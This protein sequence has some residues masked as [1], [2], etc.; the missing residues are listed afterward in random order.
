MPLIYLSASKA[1]IEKISAYE[2]GFD[3]F[4]E[5]RQPFDVRFY[6]VSILFIIFDLEI[7]FLFPLGCVALLVGCVWF[8]YYD[9]I[10]ININYWIF[11]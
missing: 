10:S 2:C 7:T 5:V 3:P 4:G 6:L 8:F 9:F 1:D 11:L